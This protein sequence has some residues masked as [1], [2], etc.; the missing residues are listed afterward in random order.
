MIETGLG[1]IFVAELGRRAVAAAIFFGW[2]D[3]LIYKFGAFD[4]TALPQRPNRAFGR[5]IR[6]AR[7]QLLGA[8]LR[9]DRSR[10]YRYAA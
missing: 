7:Q 9:P 4:R 10:L 3:V 1:T 2:R 6:W 8:Q 5:A